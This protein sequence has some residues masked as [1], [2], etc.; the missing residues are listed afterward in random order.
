M[1]KIKIIGIITAVLVIFL[2]AAFAFAMLFGSSGNDENIINKE[3]FIP[4]NSVKWQQSETTG[5]IKA[6]FKTE[7]GDFELKLAEC[8]AAEKFIEL[9]SADV[10]D[11]ADF[12]V[13]AENLFIQTGICGEPFSAAE[14]KMAC[15]RGAVGFIVDDGETYPGLVIITAED[16]S[17][18]LEGKVTVFGQIIA[19]IENVDD[20]A[21]SENAGYTGGYSAM[22]S[23]MINDI[24][25]VYPEEQIIEN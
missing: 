8:D 6:V 5:E 12:P 24:E 17:E 9:V 20:I 18:E 25:I 3:M 14:N 1:S 7:K 10:F 11:E 16:L 21:F 4:K 19:G 2:I 22:E 15:I 23:I 13:L